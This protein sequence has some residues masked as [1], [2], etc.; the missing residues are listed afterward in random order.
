MDQPPLT[1]IEKASFALG[2]AGMLLV[3]ATAPLGLVLSDTALRVVFAIDVG[4]VYVA[5]AAV[6]IRGAYGC[7]EVVTPLFATLIVGVAWFA[8]H[9]NTGTPVVAALVVGLVLWVATHL[10]TRGRRRSA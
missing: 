9:D 6:L 10:L 5:A 7:L 4:L 8:D 3:L 2:A 1:P